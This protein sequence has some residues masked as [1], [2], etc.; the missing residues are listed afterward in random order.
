MKKQRKKGFL[1]EN[2]RLSWDYM[3]E[4]SIY[5]LI[6]IFL[7][8]FGAF[9]S[10]IYQ[11]PEFVEAVRAFIESVLQE[12]SGFGVSE[13]TIYILNNNLKNSFF[14]MSF[15]IILGI[16]PGFTALANGY[17]LGFV[18]EKSVLIG[19]PGILWRLIPHGI[20]EFP[21]I[22][23]ALATGMKLGMFWFKNERKKE[24]MRRLEGSLRVF[25]FVVLPLLIIAAIV[26]GILIILVS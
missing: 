21:A 7:L 2:Y 10:L 8:F 1:N 5:M 14:A 11:P 6:V 17:V 22:I 19:G 23:L 3:K 16:I 20:F 15:G 26:E 24:L 25:L 13:M 9:L 12:T 18:A 4:S